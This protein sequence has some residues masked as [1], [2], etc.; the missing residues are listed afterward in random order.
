MTVLAP[1]T[2]RVNHVSETVGG[3]QGHG[4]HTAFC[5]LVAAHTDLGLEVGVNEDWR[6]GVLHVHTLGP[7]SLRRLV[8]HRGL[9][10]VSAHV[11]PGT[12]RGSL[13]AAQL[14]GPAF[15][16]Y[17]RTF[18]NHAHVVVAVSAAAAAELRALGVRT[19]VE[20]V[21]NAVE[22]DLF[23]N[24]PERRAAARARLGY[25]DAFT[26]LG[27]GQLQ[28]R[29]GIEEFARC[30][31]AM[32]DA[33]FVWVG[34]RQFGALSAGRAEMGD[35]VATAPRNLHFTGQLTRAGV[36]EHCRAADAFL[37][38]SRHETFGMAPVEAAF[39]GLP[40]VLRDLPVF[41]EVLGSPDA[42]LRARDVP[43]YLAHLRALQGDADLRSRLGA[44]AAAAVARY[45][46]RQVADRI[47][48]LYR[49]W[50][51]RRARS[52]AVVDG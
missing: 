37:F 18:Y 28:P 17:V 33:R 31:R 19:P 26:V 29:K 48:E 43:G 1:A 32:P 22:A 51:Q 49:T 39:A 5:D 50:S 46:S 44:D 47:A 14:Y 10:V 13:A 40:L 41:T 20:I 15:A 23:V 12:L 24:T 4:V 35:V 8:R 36:A 27:V 9:R 38:P 16:A 11:T 34:A 52:A 7:A 3:S 30:A 21:P 45:E 42:Y 25:D 2:T 6:D